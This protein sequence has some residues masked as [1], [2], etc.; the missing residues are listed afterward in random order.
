[1][2]V[3]DE[4]IS[5]SEL[6]KAIESWYRGSVLYVKELRPQTVVKDDVIP[7][8]LRHCKNPTFVTINY[9]DFWNQR[10]AP[11]SSAYCIICLKLDKSRWME[12]SPITRDI[13]SLGEFKTKRKRMGKVISWSDRRIT[14]RE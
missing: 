13:L 8:L 9:D 12:T 3:L 11:A 6:K 7:S 4:Q 14:W 5:N 2:I 1:M 10:K